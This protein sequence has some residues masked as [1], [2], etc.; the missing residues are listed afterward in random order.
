MRRF[1]KDG[2][3]KHDVTSIFKLFLLYGH[4]FRQPIFVYLAC[5]GMQDSWIILDE[6]S[7]SLPCFT[8]QTDN[9]DLVT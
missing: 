6:E 2:G 3:A 7:V 8:V 4:H 5:R 9:A 1:A